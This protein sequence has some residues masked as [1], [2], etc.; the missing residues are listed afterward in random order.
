MSSLKACCCFFSLCDRKPMS[1][2]ANRR[3]R[4]RKRPPPT[5]NSTKIL[6]HTP[7]VPNTRP[8]RLSRCR[9][10]ARPSFPF[11]D[12]ILFDCARKTCTGNQSGA[13]MPITITHHASRLSAYRQAFVPSTAPAPRPTFIFNN[14][15][16]ALVCNLK[17][18]S[19]LRKQSKKHHV[20]FLGSWR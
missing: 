17:T 12:A 19:Q 2:R 9:R 20:S 11:I 3:F 7:N 14:K 18:R 6:K 8:S 15:R 13:C 4:C 16:K 1:K 5:P 10:A